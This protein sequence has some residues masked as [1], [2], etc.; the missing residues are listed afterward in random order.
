MERDIAITI[1]P[2]HSCNMRCKHCFNGE[3]LNDIT[4]LS[5][6]SACRFLELVAAEYR[7]IGL[8]FHGGE[9]TLVGIDFYR[10]IF[11]CEKKLN[12]KY[13][14]IFSKNFTTNGVCL[15]NDLAELL[16]D[17][18]VLINVSF[19][20]PHNDILR[21]NTELVYER[22]CYLQRKEAKFRIYCV[23]TALSASSLIDTYKW[24]RDHRFNFKMVP[25]QPYGNA[26]S[27]T[28]LIMD[29]SSFVEA[30]MELY[31]YW[32]TDKSCQIH[33]FTLEE[34]L[35]L[36]SKQA[37]KTPWL[38]RKLALNPDG[39]IYPFG[40]PNDVNFCL[41]DIQ[42][43]NRIND[44][45]KSS[46]Y[47]RLMSILERNIA[48]FCKGCNS[49]HVCAGITVS[50]SFVYGCDF[51]MLKY[52]CCLADRIFQGALEINQAVFKDIER[53]D[54]DKYTCQVKKRFGVIDDNSNRIHTA[55]SYSVRKDMI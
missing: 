6:S 52:G 35:D 31:R 54:Y 49:E 15:D 27:N 11:S 19:D 17:N 28:K 29:I 22:L 26:Q 50:S 9:P 41:G 4:F 34:F 2:T 44:C 33:F 40:R 10:E 21:T 30:L 32:L 39:K 47:M 14:A 48:E 18:N 3:K 5:A 53:G 16:I 24:F 25:V 23:E 8:T 1:K 51:D 20:G 12:E 45:F 46:E 37:F 7:H 42:T 55:S 38:F 13:G 36:E 43:L